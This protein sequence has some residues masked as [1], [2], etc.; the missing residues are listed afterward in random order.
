MTQNGLFGTRRDIIRWLGALALP[1]ALGAQH[2]DTLSLSGGEISAA[3]KTAG[4]RLQAVS[5]AQHT[6]P[7]DVFQVSLEGGRTLKSSEMATEGRPQVTRVEA[8]PRSIRRAGRRAGHQ[9]AAKFR[10]SATGAV[11]NW[12]AIL[13]DGT[14]YLRYE[15]TIAAGA[16]DLPVRE[17]VLWDFDLPQVAVVGTSKRVSGGSGS[18]VPGIRASSFQHDGHRIA[19][20]VLAGA[21]VAG[22]R[23][24]IVRLLGGDRNDCAR[25]ASTGFSDLRGGPARA[26]LPHVSALQHVV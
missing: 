15:L 10:D 5:I 23:G 13:L 11:L 3:W 24:T 9:V 20:A 17:I 25:A 19:R 7:A 14:K 26:P 18:L 1:Q 8:E 21:A 4:G 6:V 12:R 16:N 22:P 2:G